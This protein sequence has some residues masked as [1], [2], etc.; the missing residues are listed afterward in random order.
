MRLDATYKPFIISV[1]AEI[2]IGVRRSAALHCQKGQPG[3]GFSWGL[4]QYPHMFP[5]P[6]QGTYLESRVTTNIGEYDFG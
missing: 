2:R 1:L 3:S 6:K 4:R 5:A